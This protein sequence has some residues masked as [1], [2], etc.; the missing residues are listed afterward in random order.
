MIKKKMVRIKTMEELANTPDVTIDKDMISC[1]RDNVRHTLIKNEY[2]PF[3]LMG[4]SDVVLH[5]R[6]QDQ[7][8]YYPTYS[9]QSG[10][11]VYDFFIAESLTEPEDMI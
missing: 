5:R 10:H 6:D 1:K 4:K 11:Y 7:H 8:W 2:P 9:I 3:K